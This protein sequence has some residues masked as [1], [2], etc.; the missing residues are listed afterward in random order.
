[1]QDVWRLFA[2][3]ELPQ[4]VR[5]QAATIIADLRR[6][7]WHARWAK[8]ESMHLTMRFYGDVPTTAVP[9]LSDAIATAIRHVGA[10]ALQTGRLG[11]FPN[12]RNPRVLWI[13]LDGNTAALN[14]LYEEI[15]AASEALGFAREARGFSPHITLGRLRPDDVATLTRI[16]QQ[17]RE[18]APREPRPVPV[19]R[20]VLYRSEL[21]PSGAVHTPLN[22]F[23][24]EAGG[25]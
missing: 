5:D 14:R 12:S 16:D 25:R 19:E 18:H 1:M 7:G 15:E 6:D 8:P 9:G 24:L 17:L 22:V 20:V 13:G 23:P 11:V 2:A 3:V 21:L 10:F 4:D